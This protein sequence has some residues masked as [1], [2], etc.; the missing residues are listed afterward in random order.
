MFSNFY[1]Q[2]QSE[3]ELKIL[4]VKSDHGGEF[5]NEP[6]ESFLKNMELSMNS[7]ILEHH[8]KMGL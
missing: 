7:L 8:N 4:K 3:K 5:V 6:F 2:V 1:T